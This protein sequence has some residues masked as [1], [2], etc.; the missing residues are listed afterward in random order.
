MLLDEGYFALI[1][2][3]NKSCECKEGGF[4]LG[5]GLVLILLFSNDSLSSSAVSLLLLPSL[6]PFMMMQAKKKKVMKKKKSLYLPYMPLT[7]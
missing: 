4:V 6:C 1:F 2:C 7:Y 5:E 3:I